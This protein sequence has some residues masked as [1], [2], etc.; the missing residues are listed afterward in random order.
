MIRQLTLFAIIFCWATGVVATS[1]ELFRYASPIVQ[2]FTKKDYKGGNQNWSITQDDN[3]FIYVG[4]SNGL[5]QF[6]GIRWKKFAL[7]GASIVRAV[8][9]DGNRIYTGS[10][11]DFGYWEKDENYNLHYTSISKLLTSKELGDEEIWW[12]VKFNNRIFFQSF[13]TTYAYDGKSVEIVVSNL[14]LILP[15]FV[16]NGHLYIQSSDAG[17]YEIGYG[18]PTLISGSELFRGKNIQMMETF[19]DSSR[20]L[21]GTERNGLYILKNNT[22][23]EWKAT[24][25]DHLK[26]HVLNRGIKINDHLFAIGTILGG[27]FIINEDGQILRQINSESGLSNNTVLSFLLDKKNNLWV[28]LDNGIDLL[29]INSPHYSFSDVTG[30]IGSV[31]TAVIHEETLYLGT[32]RGVFYKKF[33]K[34]GDAT[35]NYFTLIP[36]SQGQVWSLSVI[37]NTLFCGHNNSTY[38]IK[39]HALNRISNVSGGYNF[40]LYP[41]NSNYLVQGAYNGLFVYKMENGEWKYSHS[42]AGFNKLSKILAF[43]RANVLWLSHPY[44]GLYRMEL[45]DNLEVVKAIRAFSPE[46]KTYIN[47]L[48]S[49]IVFS[50]DSGFVYY[51]DIQNSFFQLSGV[52]DALGEYARNAHLLYAANN[53]YWI[54]KEGECVRAVMDEKQVFDID[55]GVANNILEFI[56]PGDENIYVMDTTY[57]FLMLDNGFAVFNNSWVD[58]NPEYQPEVLLREINFFNNDGEQ[59]SKYPTYGNIPFRFNHVAV[60]VAYPEFS[61]N[62]DLLYKLEGYHEQWIRSAREDEIVFQNLPFGKYTLKVK[63]AISVTTTELSIYI[64]INTP[65][66]KSTLAQ[67]I[68]WVMFIMLFAVIIV[69]YRKKIKRIQ[70][71]HEFERR[72]LLEREVAENERK[73]AEVRHENLKN[74]IRLRNSKLAK[75][76]FS[77]IHK[78]ST[79]IMVKEEL[80]KIKG[81]LGVRFPSKH[82]SRL[83]KSI[84]DDLSSENDWRMFEQSFSDVHGNFLQKLKV[85]YVDLTPADIQLCAYLKMNL[86]SK[87]VASLLNITIRGVEIRR[88]RLRKKLH[89]EHDKNLVEFI[90]AY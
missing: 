23:E 2:H 76:T 81:E 49:K 71:R 19:S 42:I 39:N 62:T 34:S 77:L 15:P 24:A 89:L 27:V 17:L 12:I 37:D 36:G 45:S 25:N 10:L 84:D 73:L 67:L 8:F 82:F 35:N 72:S 51:D 44:K 74:E 29:K 4:N 6:D 38:T 18:E 63:P 22:I 69:M 28:G 48:N 5:L 70:Q 58:M 20:I 64:V 60:Q 46:T 86:S 32:N 83:V 31:Y 88:Y 1:T 66:Y 79:L 61:L 14:G 52:N 90:M 3:G 11:G 85:E 59:L 9:A 53:R 16:V 78:N 21:I 30:N 54:F 57:T 13:G 33:I 40:L 41:Y 43:E 7:P 65:F 68:Y 47:I 87:E 80:T 56:I 26:T 75:S 55:D 50:S